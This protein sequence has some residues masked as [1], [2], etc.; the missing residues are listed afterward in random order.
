MLPS[1]WRVECNIARLGS[2]RD[3]I[4]GKDAAPCVWVKGPSLAFLSRCN[5]LI[6]NF[7]MTR[8][9]II[10]LLKLNEELTL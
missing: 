10:Y 5:Q 3:C 9:M 4:R 1:V 2:N 8:C 6:V 7:G